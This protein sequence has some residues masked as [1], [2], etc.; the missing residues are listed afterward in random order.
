[1]IGASAVNHDVR[2]SVD[3]RVLPVIARRAM[4]LEGYAARLGILFGYPDYSGWRS[5][6]DTTQLI[7][8]RDEAVAKDG[9][10][11]YYPV[12]PYGTGY[13]GKGAAFDIDVVRWPEGK[14]EAWAYATLGAFAP[15]I[16]LR[17]GGIFPG[18][19]RD[20]FHFELPVSVSEAQRLFNEWRASG[21]IVLPPTASYTSFAPPSK[22]GTAGLS[23]E[24]SKRIMPT[25]AAS[26]GVVALLAL[27]AVGFFLRGV[28]S[29]ES[30]TLSSGA[31]SALAHIRAIAAVASTLR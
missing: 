16:G 22:A 31:L 24:V 14:T 2:D 29:Y 15:R 18:R 9:A 28:I 4:A 25:G 8:W 5:Q 19:S 27:V 20:V 12:A 30:V 17:W 1:M 23:A 3:L 13:H 11:A 6:A 7:R 26:L 10:A 21:R